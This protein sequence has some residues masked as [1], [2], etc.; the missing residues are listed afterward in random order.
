[1]Y[2]IHESGRDIKGIRKKDLINLSK[3]LPLFILM[4]QDLANN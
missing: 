2:T 3:S 4:L 1:M